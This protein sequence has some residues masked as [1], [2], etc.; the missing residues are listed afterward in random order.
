M[1]AQGAKEWFVAMWAFGMLV[2]LASIVTGNDVPRAFVL[3]FTVLWI[4]A[5]SAW[6]VLRRRTDPAPFEPPVPEEPAR[7]EP[8]WARPREED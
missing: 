1:T 5:G 6:I 3:A 7:P 2:A 4:G 8:L